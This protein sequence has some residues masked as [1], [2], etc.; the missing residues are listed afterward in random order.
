MDDV[1]ASIII[2]CQTAGAVTSINKLGFSLGMLGKQAAD[3]SWQ[4][5]KESLGAFNATQDASWKFEKTFRDSMGT[6]TQAVRELMSEYNLSEQTAKTMLTDTA[7]VLKGFG[8]DEKEALKMSESVSRMGVDLASFTGHAG[9]AKDA[10]QAITAAMLGETERMKGYGTVIHMDDKELRELTKTIATNKGVTED[11]ARAMAILETIIKKNKDAIGDYKAEGENW[12]QAQNDQREAMIELK[13]AFG[14]LIYGMFNIYPS[15]GSITKA[16]RGITSYIKKEGK[17]WAYALSSF[18][19]NIRE[20]VETVLVFLDPIWTGITAGFKNIANSGRWLYDNWEKIWDNMSD[21]AI[22]AGKDIL[23]GILLVPKLIIK[24]F[25]EGFS[26]IGSMAVDQFKNIK[27]LFTGKIG[28]GDFYRKSFENVSS[29]FSEH[30]DH[31]LTEGGKQF[32]E[33]G[34][35]T[36]RALAQAGASPFPELATPDFSAW[37]DPDKALKRVKRESDARR[38]KL[39][40]R[41]AKWVERPERKDRGGVGDKTTSRNDFVV[42][43]KK[44]ANDIFRSRETTQSAILANSLEGIR[45][46]SRQFINNSPQMQLVNQGKRT[47]ALLEKVERSLTKMN[48]NGTPLTFRNA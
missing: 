1:T 46:Q 47:I 43:M 15:T 23:N 48:Q 37:T 31:I 40:E 12:T 26:A 16:I 20:S 41:F 34:K 35:N 21:I 30:I 45:L 28:F 44:I 13:S 5:V 29:K 27:D 36:E 32:G 22:A 14:G 18:L 25:S 2:A 11:Q 19:L 33:L 9:G 17:A 24:A 42:S 38:Q 6:A 7:G 10:V 39:N 8:F 4:F 3:F